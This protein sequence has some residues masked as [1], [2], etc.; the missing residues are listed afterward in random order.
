[1]DICRTYLITTDK[2]QK[3]ALGAISAKQAEHFFLAMRPNERVALIEELPQ[4]P[5]NKEP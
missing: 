3:M 2:G 1:M 4:L 5:Q